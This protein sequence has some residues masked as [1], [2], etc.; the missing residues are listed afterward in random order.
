MTQKTFVILNH[1][2]E[3]R[4]YFNSW[5]ALDAIKYGHDESV[6]LAEEIAKTVEVPHAGI[7]S[8]P[9]LTSNRNGLYWH[10]TVSGHFTSAE[11]LQEFRDTVTKACLKLGFTPGR[12]N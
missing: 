7:S 4:C 12:R 6:K 3:L 5:L 9:M 1:S 10:I 11:D 2:V 8:I